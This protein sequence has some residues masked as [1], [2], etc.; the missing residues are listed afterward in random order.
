MQLV[1]Q[2]ELNG[3]LAAAQFATQAAQALFVLVRRCPDE[4]LLA[5]PLRHLLAQSHGRALV[6]LLAACETEK[7]AQF[8]FGL[9]LHPDEQAAAPVLVALPL[10]HQTVNGTPATKIEIAPTEIGPLCNFQRIP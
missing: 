7:C 10:L 8:V 3:E 9:L 2:E 1:A 5:K 6:D 4:Q